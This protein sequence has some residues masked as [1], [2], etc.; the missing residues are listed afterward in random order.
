[1]HDPDVVLIGAIYAARERDPDGSLS[2][3]VHTLV[4][5][6]AAHHPAAS[7]GGTIDEAIEVL[8]VLLQPGDV[9]LTLGAGDSNL[10]GADVLRRLTI[11][12]Q[13]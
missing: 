2:G 6:I 8:M 10:V 13:I 11:M 7:Y 3:L 9:L 1:R 12:E 4:A 5:R